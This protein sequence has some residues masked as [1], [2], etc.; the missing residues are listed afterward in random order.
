[1]KNRGASAHENTSQNKT[2]IG[3]TLIMAS[4]RSVSNERPKNREDGSKLDDF[5]IKS[6]ASTQTIFRI[7]FERT[8]ERT[9]EPNNRNKQTKICFNVVKQHVFLVSLLKIVTCLYKKKS[10]K[11]FAVRIAKGGS[12]IW[13]NKADSVLS[14]QSRWN[15][16][17]VF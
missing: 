6:I 8:S 11:H 9:N 16:H 2:K 3:T 7:V 12:S 5:W 13:A 10:T 1:M 17:S 14:A 4:R 15:F